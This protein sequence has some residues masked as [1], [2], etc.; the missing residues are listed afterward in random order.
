MGCPFVYE[1]LFLQCVCAA[2]DRFY[3]FVSDAASA[4]ALARRSR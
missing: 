2:F 3:C 1:E 4:L